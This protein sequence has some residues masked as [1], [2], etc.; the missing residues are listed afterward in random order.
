MSLSAID[1]PAY[2]EEKVYTPE[3]LAALEDEIASL[4]DEKNMQM[5]AHYYTDA[6]VQRLAEK[7]G[8]CVSDSLDMARFGVQ[9]KAKGLV[10]A[11]VY[12]MG[13]TAKILSPEKQILMPAL[14]ATCSLD[15]GC[16]PEAFEAF[17]AKHPGRE[18]VVYVNTSARVKALADWSVTSSIALELVEH[19]HREGKRILWGP[20]RH[21]GAYIQE[22]TGADMVLWPGVCI[23]HEGFKVDALQKLQKQH[24]EAAIL[25]HPEAPKAI[26]DLAHCIGSTKQLI[27]AAQTLPQKTLIVAT[28]QGIFYKMQQMAPDK[29][30]IPAPSGGKGATCTSCAHCPWM[31]MNAL[32]G[33]K[34]ALLNPEKHEVLVEEEIRQKAKRSLDR[35]IAFQA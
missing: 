19:L 16:P 18:V 3:A 9:S 32:E 4:L 7:T 1:V 17:C 13:E 14:Q 6:L 20:D 8:G 21:L 22:K 30:L 12:F 26:L 10:V 35:M 2:P 33:I 15:L 25:A 24:P 34:D 28:D 29:T 31:A 11:G 5:V 23:V 27:Q